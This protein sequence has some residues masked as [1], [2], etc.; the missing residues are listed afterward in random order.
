MLVVWLLPLAVKEAYLKA[1]AADPVSAFGGVLI[2]N[3]E[4]DIEAAEELN[5]LFFEVLIA[6]AYSDEALQ[7]LTSKKNRI[8]LKRKD[9]ALPVVSVKTLLNGL[10]RQDMDSHTE[11]V[12]DLRS[13]TT[14]EVTTDEKEALVICC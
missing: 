6:P 10:I 5:K 9:V 7:I 4:V 13:V 11:T 3:A 1:L 12:D 8:L 14:R 2:T